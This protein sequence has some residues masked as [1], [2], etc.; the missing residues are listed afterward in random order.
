ML[1]AALVC[2][3]VAGAG[4]TPARAVSNTGS[5]FWATDLNNFF[6][7]NFAIVVSNTG[8]SDAS[9]TV[10]D[11]S[12]TLLTA[13]VPAG[14]LH[15]FK[16]ARN[17]IS[18]TTQ[19]TEGVYRVASDQPIVA[20]QFNPL[21]NVYTNDA[22][23][24]LP[25][26]AFGTEYRVLSYQPIPWYNTPSFVAIVAQEDATEVTFTSSATTAPGIGI[27]SLAPGGTLTKTLNRFDVLNI[28]GSGTTDD[29][30][31]SR[32]QSDKP[33]AVFAGN[34]CTF[35][36]GNQY[37]CDHL[38]EQLFPT[39]TWGSN[40]AACRSQ[41][42]GTEADL[43]RVIAQHDST[44]VTTTPA[45]P[46]TPATLNAGQWFEFDA[47]TDV[48]IDADKPVMAAQY[49]VSQNSGAGT[50]DPS[51]ILEVPVQQFRAAYR[52]LTPD[53]FA[54]DYVTIAA[55]NGATVNLDG[56]AIPSASFT[57][58]G[59]SGYSCARV[60]V[61]D[62]AHSITASAPVG[63]SVYGYDQYASYGYP[64]GLELLDINC[65]EGLRALD[66]TPAEGAVSKTVH[67][68]VE[69]IVGGIDAGAREQLH[70]VNCDV[71]VPVET[72]VDG[73]LP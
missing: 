6:G 51:M 39:S 26:T 42:R 69:P 21:E 28:E 71:V 46:G 48:A 27:D 29:L 5:E 19:R 15:T 45:V 70:R 4:F 65:E 49:L 59:D 54:F 13:T 44:T 17:I 31:G 16:L 40:F 8:S 25:T 50:G 37:A 11:V 61:S 3:T 22:S 12:A 63:I 23:L 36:P 32:V 14:G 35:V 18:G 33:I 55:P 72:V 60:L 20:Y 30:T 1:F 2:A 68:Q 58:L 57:Q 9:V 10:S 73:A 62:G 7:G 53:T 47:A 43:I 41:Q 24:L 52:F 34:Q 38:E 66:G 67:D 56:T 64:G